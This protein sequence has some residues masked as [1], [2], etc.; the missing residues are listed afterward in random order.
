MAIIKIYCKKS[1]VRS[2]GEAP[3]YLVLRINNVERLILTKKKIEPHLFDNKREKVKRGASNSVKLNS[4][5]QNEKDRLNEIILDFNMRGKAYDHDTIISLFKRENKEGFADFC[6]EELKKE[7]STLAW[8]TYEQYEYCIENLE[9]YAP[10]ATIHQIDYNFLRK[11]EY[12]LSS[13]KGRVKNGYYHDFAT[14]RKF[15]KIAIKQGLTNEYPFDNF[16][17]GTEEV[18]K[19]WHPE[20]ELKKLEELIEENK[21]SDKLAHTLRYYLIACN[22]GLRFGDIQKLSIALCNGDKDR[23][24]IDGSIHLVQGKGK[25][26]NRIPLSNKAKELLNYEFDRPLKQSNSRVNE[27]LEE[28]MKLAKIKKHISFHCSRHTFAINALQKGVTLKALSQILGH[29]TAT[30][31]EIYAKYVNE[32]L[33]NEIAKLN[34]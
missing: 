22:T 5:L 2:N 8:K 25:K 29:R 11:Y 34:S 15:F 9:A 20:I 16:K 18:K 23:Y 31:T 24:I 28:I 7:K 33:D 3:I 6:R 17:F 21:L 4:Y 1:K 26:I 14:I 27:D 10:G 32:G 30:T 19:E 12:H 13:V